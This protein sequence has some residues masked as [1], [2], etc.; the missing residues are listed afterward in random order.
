MNWAI[1]TMLGFIAAVF[2]GLGA[3]AFALWRRGQAPE[4]ESA[5]TGRSELREALT[6]AAHYPEGLPS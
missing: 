4:S 3:F 5:A 1:I 6:A 2:A